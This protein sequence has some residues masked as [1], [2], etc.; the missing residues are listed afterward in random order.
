M[1]AKQLAA[2]AEALAA[3]VKGKLAELAPCADPSA[4]AEGCAKDFIR[5]FGGRAHR[6]PLEAAEIDALL[7]V[8]RVGAKGGPPR[9]SS[10]ASE[11]P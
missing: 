7:A 6:R 8:Y 1:L 4:Q 2:S 10:Q 11:R 5:S 3:E 9:S